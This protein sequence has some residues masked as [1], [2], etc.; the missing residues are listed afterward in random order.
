MKNKIAYHPPEWFAENPSR[1]NTLRIVCGER[2]DSS[3]DD[4]GRPRYIKERCPHYQAFMEEE[5]L[6]GQ[7]VE[8]KRRRISE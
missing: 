8:V 4:Q 6:K 7:A 3:E 2:S 1:S 5:T